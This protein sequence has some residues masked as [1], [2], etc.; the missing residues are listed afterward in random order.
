MIS[1][2]WNKVVVIP[3]YKKGNKD[4]VKNYRGITLMDNADYKIYAE[5]LRKKLEKEVE[6]KKILQDTQM[7]FGRKIG[8]RDA[9]MLL[10]KL[11]EG[12]F[13]KVNRKKL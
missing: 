7:G 12:A 2:G 11:V 10:K 5:V 9:M 6:G 8:T 1:E 13:N 3:V 4:E